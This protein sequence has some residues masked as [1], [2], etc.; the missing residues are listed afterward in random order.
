MNVL[1]Q[2]GCPYKL[3]KHVYGVY[4]VTGIILFKRNVLFYMFGLR[5]H[6][7]KMPL[8]LMNKCVNSFAGLLTENWELSFEKQKTLFALVFFRV[9]AA[10]RCTRELAAL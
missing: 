5:S 4:C 1:V 6:F 9:S 7:L 2:R 8:V 10:V 3:T